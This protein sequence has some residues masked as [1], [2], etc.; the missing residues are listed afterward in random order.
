MENNS[1][2]NNK[3][4]IIGCQQLNVNDIKTKKIDPLNNTM[5]Y[6]YHDVNGKCEPILFQTKYMTLQN[7]LI[8]K[9]WGT[10]KDD[11]KTIFLRRLLNVNDESIAELFNVC[12]TIDNYMKAQKNAIIAETN[13]DP[14]K[15]TYINIVN[16]DLEHNCE[17]LKLK[18]NITKYDKATEM[19]N[20]N[21]LCVRIFYKGQD[22]K[23]SKFKGDR[24]MDH[25]LTSLSK[26]LKTGTKIRF[27]LSVNKVWYNTYNYGVSIKVLQ[28]EI[29]D[30]VVNNFQM[31]EKL[32]D[33]NK[34][35]FKKEE[36]EV[37]KNDDYKIFEN[38]IKRMSQF[39]MNKNK[40]ETNNNKIVNI[41]KNGEQSMFKYDET[42]YSE[43]INKITIDI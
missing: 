43:P 41:L 10:N 8:S 15:Y 13:G 24:W 17:K 11:F 23:Y 2:P 14:D 28:M 4:N 19:K 5:L 3:P 25:K 30:T 27:I 18:L 31:L 42:E 20:I 9:K 7:N 32:K 38:D 22:A 35:M 29:D 21:D 6:P 39:G 37:K 16:T 33:N 40:I 12:H 1:K 26:I 34:N 36:D